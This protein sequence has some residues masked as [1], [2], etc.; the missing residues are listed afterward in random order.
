[1]S[2]DAGSEFVSACTQ[3]PPLQKEGKRGSRRLVF[4][5]RGKVEGRAAGERE[6]V[7]AV[8]VPFKVG[9]KGGVGGLMDV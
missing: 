8:A 7:I 2:L 5:M 9:L 4:G 1:M 3:V 6:E